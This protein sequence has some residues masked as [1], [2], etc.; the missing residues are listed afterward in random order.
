MAISIVSKTKSGIIGNSESIIGYT[1]L[2]PFVSVSADG[3]YIAFVSSASNF[4]AADT[5]TS[6][7]IYL[8][9]TVTGDIKIVSADANGTA[10]SDINGAPAISA[11]GRYVAFVGSSNSLT[12]ELGS[13]FNDIYLKDMQTGAVRLITPRSA[14]GALSAESAGPS[15]SADGRYVAF[16]SSGVF[17]A[18]DSDI[19][20]DDV[21]VFDTVARTYQQVSGGTTAP[22]GFGADSGDASI[23]AN[24]RYVVYESLSDNIVAGDTNALFDIFVYD[25]QTGATK[26]ASTTA[27]GAQS[28]GIPSTP[29]G[30][31]SGSFNAAIS[32]DGRFVAFD[33]N[34]NNLVAGDT[35]AYDVFLKDMVTGFVVRVSTSSS[36]AQANG[37]SY[38][39]SISADGRFIAYTSEATNLDPGDTDLEPDIYVW[40]RLTG[41]TTLIASTTK[42][43][44]S[45]NLNAAISSDGTKIIFDSN[46]ATL[47]GGDTNARRDVFIA[48]NTAAIPKFTNGNDVAF[49]VLKNTTTHGLL[50]NDKITGTTGVD[51]MYGDDGAD[52]LTGS[53]GN[54]TLIGGT[55]IDTM[56]GGDGNDTYDVDNAADVT[57]ETSAL[58]MGGVDLVRST[59]TRT[60]GANI[61]NL[62]LLGAL[63][64]NGTGNALNNV[65][66][67]NG[68]VN[69][70]SGGAG[71]DTLT[72][73]LGA[74]NMT[75]GDGNDTYNVDI[76][77]DSTTETSALPAGGI[78][79]V[80]STVTRTL[81]AN[82]ENLT[83]LG[84]LAING[85]GNTLNNVIIGNGAV[86]KLDGGAG[87]DTLTGG[88]GA[89]NMIGGA[90]NDTYDVDNASDLTTETIAAG[91]G[92]DLVLSSVTRV[93]GTNLEKLTLTGA[94][95][96]NGTGNTLAN[97][98]TG[99]AA[100][101]VLN[102][103]TNNDTLYGGAGADTL[104]GGTGIDT[105]FGGDGNDIYD[106]DVAGD[107]TN[108]TSALAAGGIDLVRSFVTRTLGANIENLT[109]MGAAAIN[110]TGNGLSNRIT[111]N[112]GANTLDGG[113]AND[114]MD[115]GG[116]NDIYVAD[117]SGDSVSETLAGA[118]GGVDL[119]RAFATFTLGANIEN[120]TLM[121][122]SAIN[123]TGNDLNNTFIGNS[124]ANHF[125]G[126]LG[127][128]TFYLGVGDTVADDAGIDTV[129]IQNF[130]FSLVNTLV[131]RA[132]LLGTTGVTLGGSDGNDY[133]DV[134]QNTAA[135]L[136]VGA[137]GNDTFVIGANDTITENLG[138][139]TDTVYVVASPNYSLVGTNVE[140]AIMLGSAGG[141]LGGT[142]G[143]DFLDV[144]QDTTSNLVV[145][146]NGSDTYVIGA[147]DVIAEELNEGIDTVTSRTITIDL[148]AL[149]PSATNDLENAILLGGLALNIIG[150]GTNNVITGN[151]ANNTLTGA[152]GLD[153]FVFNTALNSVTNVDTITDFSVADD[154]IN[155]ENAIFT[156]LTAPG[157]LSGTALFI[158]TA[159]HLTT[160]RII[161]NSATGALYYD[162]D[163][164]TAGGVAAVKIANLA[165]GLA[166]SAADFVVI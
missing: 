85:T 134:S 152:A 15:I 118:A 49:L 140:R 7:D 73:G 76:A 63:A 60:L 150:N 144:S 86:N 145:G 65:I 3:R 127:N 119:V 131:E 91:G 58:V 34:A 68:A 40:D 78:D 24:G 102:G 77:G 41:T 124:V 135:N 28:T 82:I 164:N 89:D 21:Y 16:T 139:G 29:Q 32:A 156:A 137:N 17:S 30:G 146:A 132:I 27:T 55:G 42:T 61:E 18:S 99:N 157:V 1:G 165:A 123:G 64:I 54:D 100:A 26:R 109:L 138:E 110:G 4:A 51:T 74:D 71:N 142:D 166:L 14:N 147:G 67:G 151:S 121:G 106:V 95:A 2:D 155:L 84:T 44:L 161:Y 101:N 59:V 52:T 158:G 56:I 45:H 20:L 136:V 10:Y 141:K 36:G 107:I 90:G 104:T 23:S 114:T 163:G 115:G 122:T 125:N 13:G 83:L 128:D 93:L 11:D 53:A 37:N 47:V 6:Y 62:T 154:T 96:I 43:N 80:R 116:G 69:V 117:S 57:T 22:Q 113:G 108:E 130:A 87:N 75:G 9:D 79:L 148:L 160:D 12:P 19:G 39:A 111:G 98:I 25:R 143:S 162:A 88:F 149:D 81:G 33:S 97:V 5:D 66:V 31:N 112:S 120:L 46:D 133:L 94:A 8:K 126:G 129:Y 92:I 48:D 70:L 50:G 35:N 105:M 38:G 153:T 72:G 103:G 159:A